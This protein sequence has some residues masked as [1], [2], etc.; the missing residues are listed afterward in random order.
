MKVWA[1][2]VDEEGRPVFDFGRIDG[3]DLAYALRTT[4]PRGHRITVYTE[5]RRELTA[6]QVAALTR[7]QT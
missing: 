6:E 2:H 7:K 1:T 4:I 5:D 3:R